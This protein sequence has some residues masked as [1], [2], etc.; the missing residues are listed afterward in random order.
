M[1][2]GGVKLDEQYGMTTVD[3]NNLG[4]LD[5]PFILDKDM[6]QFFYVKDMTSKPRKRTKANTSCDE[7]K[8]HIVFSGKRT[9]MGVEDK[10][11][12]SQDYNQFGEIPPFRVNTD[13][14]LELNDEDAPWLR[15]NRKQGTLAKK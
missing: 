5:E 6:A 4:Y 10:I 7:P 14:S 12:M 11:D 13:T 8:R 3:L 2:G 9:I 1:T 15:H